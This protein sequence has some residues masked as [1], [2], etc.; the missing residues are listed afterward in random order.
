MCNDDFKLVQSNQKYWIC[1]DS[2]LNL[3]YVFK[4]AVKWKE[5]ECVI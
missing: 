1:D 3:L 4:S 5:Q 2:T